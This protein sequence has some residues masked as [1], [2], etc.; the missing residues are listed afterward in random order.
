MAS[1]TPPVNFLHHPHSSS[2]TPLPTSHP[3]R[4]SSRRLWTAGRITALGAHGVRAA[5][6]PF[7]PGH[8]RL[9]TRPSHHTPRPLQTSPSQISNFKSQ[10]PSARRRLWT[11]GRI[12]ALGAHGVRAARP[13]NTPLPTRAPRQRC[14]HVTGGRASPRAIPPENAPNKIAPRRGASTSPHKPPGTLS[15]T[16]LLSIH[17]APPTGLRLRHH[18]TNI[19]KTIHAPSGSTTS[20]PPQPESLA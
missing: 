6:S 14:Q 4:T 5:R 15:P 12:T 7:K 18:H 9:R 3:L 10:I 8:A 2:P 16:S 20:S 19:P 11:A 17:D 1:H 13:P